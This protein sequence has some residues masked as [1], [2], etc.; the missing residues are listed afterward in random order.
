MAWALFLIA[1]GI[2]AV[3][4]LPRMWADRRF[5]SVAAVRRR[6]V[7]L[8]ESGRSAGPIR[9][10]YLSSEGPPRGAG[11]RVSRETILSRRRRALAVLLVAVTASLVAAVVSRGIWLLSLHG[12]ADA[13]L[14]WYV[15]TLRRIAIAR[16]ERDRGFAASEPA[17]GVYPSQVRIVGSR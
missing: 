14:I 6:G 12:F 7:S 11:D 4:L 15:V 9:S 3:M 10:T 5:A 8:P 2:W 13:M 16:R 1:A 17:R